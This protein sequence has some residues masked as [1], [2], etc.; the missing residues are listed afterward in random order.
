MP[1]TVPVPYDLRVEIKKV[2]ALD[3]TRSARKI[4]K[5]FGLHH[6]TVGRILSQTPS[7]PT[8]TLEPIKHDVI[9]RLLRKGPLSTDELAKAL[10]RSS[11]EVDET[12]S[13]MKDRGAIIYQTANGLH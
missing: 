6:K 2:H 7:D 10:S 12:I 3:P 1:K 5:E 8:P 11:D 9:R 13:D 4:A